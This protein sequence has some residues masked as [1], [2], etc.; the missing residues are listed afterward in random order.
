VH[1]SGGTLSIIDTSYETF[2]RVHRSG[3]TFSGVDTSGGTL[4]SIPWARVLF[5]LK[6]FVGKEYFSDRGNFWA[7]VFFLRK[8][9]FRQK[10]SS[11]LCPNANTLYGDFTVSVMW[12]G[13]RRIWH[14]ANKNY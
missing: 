3:G 14:A 7:R 6:F 13:I 2:T 9:F 12:R 1:T 11:H 8:S 10:Y 5:G 4:Y